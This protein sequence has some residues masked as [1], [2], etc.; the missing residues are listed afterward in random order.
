M[1]ASLPPITQVHLTPCLSKVFPVC[2]LRM[3]PQYSNWVFPVPFSLRITCCG[4]PLSIQT[5]S[6]QCLSLSLTCSATYTEQNLPSPSAE[7]NQVTSSWK[8]VSRIISSPVNKT[9]DPQ[10]IQEIRE[11]GDTHSNS[12]GF[13]EGPLLVSRLWILVEFRQRRGICSGPFVVA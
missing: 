5:E 3:T 13:P 7:D 6:S 1:T 8:Q 2:K 12:F 4:W 9:S 11:P 10:P